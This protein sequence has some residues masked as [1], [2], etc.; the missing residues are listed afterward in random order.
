M[1]C[2][3]LFISR[4]N[5]EYCMGNLEAQEQSLLRQQ[6][7]ETPGWNYYSCLLFHFLLVRFV[8][9]WSAEQ[10]PGGWQGSPGMCLQGSGLR[11]PAIDL[12]LGSSEWWFWIWGWCLKEASLLWCFAAC[13]L[14]FCSLTFLLLVV[15][16][17]LDCILCITMSKSVIRYLLGG[18]L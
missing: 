8:W 3:L 13:V 12:P 4:V 16:C 5:L 6:T 2:V 18:L 10:D 17:T 1:Q 14:L 7:S 9:S 11:T 15:V